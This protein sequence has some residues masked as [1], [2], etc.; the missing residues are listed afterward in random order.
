MAGFPKPLAQWKTWWV[1][2]DVADLI[3]KSIQ[4]CMNPTKLPKGKLVEL[5]YGK[6]CQADLEDPHTNSVVEGMLAGYPPEKEPSGYLLGDV[7]MRID[8]DVGHVIPKVNPL[9]EKARRDQ[10]LSQGAAMKL[11]LSY[12]RNATWRTEKGRVPAVTY[13]KEIARSKGRPTRKKGCSP[14]PSTCSTLSAET[15]VLGGRS[16]S[17]ST[18]DLE[19]LVVEKAIKNTSFRV[20]QSHFRMNKYSVTWVNS[21]L[22]CPSL[23]LTIQ[24]PHPV[25]RLEKLMSLLRP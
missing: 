15:L 19:N 22:L 16:P 11:L 12:V 17:S 24:G 18:N 5:K 9:E 6:V 14:S 13:L 1:N 3:A 23:N 25:M 7:V 2:T 4:S 8:K 21:K 10:A 20:F